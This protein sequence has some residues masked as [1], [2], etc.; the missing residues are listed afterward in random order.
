MTIPRTRDTQPIPTRP[1]RTHHNKQRATKYVI[2][3]GGDAFPEYVTRLYP[4]ST[5]ED[6]K[7]MVNLIYAYVR[8]NGRVPTPNE[9]NRIFE[10]LYTEPNTVPLNPR[11]NG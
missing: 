5:I 8:K 1:A 3:G 4:S 9:C 7:Q 10:G 6:R 11:Q 2:R